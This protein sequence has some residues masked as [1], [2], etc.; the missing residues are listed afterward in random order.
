MSY[1]VY[2]GVEDFNVTYN[3]AA[4]FYDHIAPVEGGRG[5]LYELDGLTGR[6][7]LVLLQGALQEIERTRCSLWQV[8]AIGEP[9]FCER[10]DAPNGWGSAIGGILF[11]SLLMAACALNPRKKVRVS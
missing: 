7:A 4:L 9:K 1:D 3:L 5:G 6:A 11:L 2:I 10:Y 8:Q